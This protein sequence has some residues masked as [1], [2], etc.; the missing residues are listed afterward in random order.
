MKRLRLTCSRSPLVDSQQPSDDDERRTIGSDI[1]DASELLDELVLVLA[2]IFRSLPFRRT[3]LVSSAGCSK[4]NIHWQG[5]ENIE[6]FQ[7]L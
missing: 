2:R 4:L 7:L 3:I 6:S 1:T 5:K